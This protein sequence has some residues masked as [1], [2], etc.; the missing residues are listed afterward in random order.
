MIARLMAMLYVSTVAPVA[1]QAQS[2]SQPAAHHETIVVHAGRLMTDPARPVAG[3]STIT[4]VDGRIQSVAAGLLPPPAGA[5]LI[6][7]ANRTVLP[8]LIDAHVHLVG[9]SRAP[10]WRGAVDTDDYLTLLGAHNAL[11]TLR[12]GFT[13]VRDLG[14]PGVTGF[15]L[16]RAIDEGLIEGPRMLVAGEPLSTI[17]GHGDTAGFR[18][19]VNEVLQGHNTCTGADQCAA[20][21]REQ[22]RNGADVIKFMAT[23]GVLSQGDRGLGHRRVL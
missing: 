2:G 14:S 10:F 23:G 21:V 8:G 6:D 11:V 22:A 5:R 15:A 17:G 1:A 18:P 19:E 4:I 9:D 20:R 13:T 7:L 16:R 3:P 12:A